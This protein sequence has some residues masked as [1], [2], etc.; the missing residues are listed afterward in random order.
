MGRT[1]CLLQGLSRSMHAAI[2]MHGAVAL[3]LHF[4][5][6]LES[7]PEQI[8]CSTACRASGD[9]I[10]LASLLSMLVPGCCVL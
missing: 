5:A 1:C 4:V 10:V 3:Q 8:T 2:S 7:H 6:W 9:W